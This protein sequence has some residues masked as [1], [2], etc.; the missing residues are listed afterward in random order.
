M[1]FQFDLIENIFVHN[2]NTNSCEIIISENILNAQTIFKVSGSTSISARF[3]FQ[4]I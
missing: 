1:H 2:K 4:C 3:I